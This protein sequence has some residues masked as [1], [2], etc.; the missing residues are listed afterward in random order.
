MADETFR[1]P[2]SSY[3]QLARIIQAYGQFSVEA[4]LDEVAAAVEGR[5]PHSR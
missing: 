2:R 1:L 4:T 3:D 5:L